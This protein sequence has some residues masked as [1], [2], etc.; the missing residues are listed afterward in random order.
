MQVKKEEEEEETS[1]VKVD[2]GKVCEGEGENRYVGRGKGMQ[3]KRKKET[4]EKR[5][6]KRNDGGKDT[7]IK[8]KE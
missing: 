3:V 4:G 1:R 7:K 2:R 5:G 6:R 8:R